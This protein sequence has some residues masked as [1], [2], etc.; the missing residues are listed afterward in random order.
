MSVGDERGRGRQAGQAAD[1]GRQRGDKRQ[2]ER[3]ACA[4]QLRW[5]LAFDLDNLCHELLVRAFALQV[6]GDLLHVAGLYLQ[7]LHFRHREVHV[8]SRVR[9]LVDFRRRREPLAIR[10][11]MGEKAGQGR[12]GR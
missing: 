3:K 10:L 4:A 6:L 8:Q 12:K 2:R 7:H 1:S 11:P 9:D 5:A